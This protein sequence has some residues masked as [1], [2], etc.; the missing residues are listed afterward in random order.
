MTD[1]HL[2]QLR[3]QIAAIDERIFALA[4]ERLALARRIGALKS[5]AGQPITVPE[6]ERLV[7]AR[8]R[9]HA[10]TLG[11]DEGVTESLARLLIRS[12]VAA[13]DAQRRQ[14][15][16]LDGLSP[17]TQRILIA[18]GRGRMGSWLTRLFTAHGH[19]VTHYDP[20]GETSGDVANSPHPGI[21]EAARN[22]DTVIL[23][24]PIMATSSLICE[25][26][27]A[28]TE[29][30]VFDICS[31]KTP[32][33]GAIRTALARGLRIG[34]AHP[35]FGPDVEQLTGRNILVCDTGDREATAQ[36]RALFAATT[37]HLSEIT[38]AQH[39]HLMSL[40]LGLP[41]LLNLVFARTLQE[42]SLPLAVL[43]DIQSTTF[44]A[45]L[46]LADAV[47]HEQTELYYEIQAENAYTPDML[48]ALRSA[49]DAF[50]SATQSHN[51]MDFTRLMTAARAYC[52]GRPGGDS[53]I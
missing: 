2:D 3:E 12:S 50:A 9:E 15:L 43:E 6:I 16:V 17:P 39:D 5:E 44:A 42:S 46:A 45:Q 29:A 36:V 18:G 34:S 26:T 33:T 37:A 48:A 25:L 22:Q 20:F 30:L 14:Q 47:A 1:E 7:I 31:L 41:H 27:A 19:I 4:A 21:A 32:L 13:Q 49:L 24:T 38:L 23:A 28:M 8:S 51:R 40:V 10:R 11:L 52:D 53:S 35:M